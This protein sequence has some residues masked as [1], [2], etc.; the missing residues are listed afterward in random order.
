MCVCVRVCLGQSSGN[1]SSVF[2]STDATPDEM[3][4]ISEHFKMKSLA[5]GTTNPAPLIR[6][7]PP[8]DEVW[9]DIGAVER[10]LET[11]V[12]EPLF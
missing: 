9:G 1:F 2:V 6:R 7:L 5:S 4:V 12:S 11:Q 3:G 8:E 10:W